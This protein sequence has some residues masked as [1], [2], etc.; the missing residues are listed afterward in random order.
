MSA[1]FSLETMQAR[2][3]WR[4][5]FQVLGKKRRQLRIEQPVKMAS[6][7]Q[8]KLKSSSDIQKLKVFITSKSAPKETLKVL[9][10]E[11]KCTR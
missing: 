7:N 5:I 2:R 11:G 1:N 3:Q 10:S 8:G 6:I 4:N 9:H